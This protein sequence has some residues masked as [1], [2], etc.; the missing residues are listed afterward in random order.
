V[1]DL[2][3]DGETGIWHLANDGAM[4]WFDFARAIARGAALD[5]GLVFARETSPTRCTS[6]A[7]ER[8]TLLRPLDQAVA[9]CLREIG[10]AKNISALSD[11]G[12]TPPPGSAFPPQPPQ[13]PA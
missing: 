6:L 3:I 4:S 9:A 10:A 5:A 12:L 2:L 1:L 13:A 8:G 11:P 7:S